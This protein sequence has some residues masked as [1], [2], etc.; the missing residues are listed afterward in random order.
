MLLA[1]QEQADQIT[2]VGLEE[3]RLRVAGGLAAALQIRVFLMLTL[4]EMVEIRTAHRDLVTVLAAVVQAVLVGQAGMGARRVQVV[5]EVWRLVAAAAVVVVQ[6]VLAVAIRRPP[7]AVREV[8]EVVRPPALR[9]LAE[10]RRAARAETAD[11]VAVL[12]VVVVVVALLR[13]VQGV[14]AQIGP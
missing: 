2:R 1:G 7:A 12:G 11:L 13:G 3:L 6:T 14:P 9:V 8:R 4:A 10:R 5:V